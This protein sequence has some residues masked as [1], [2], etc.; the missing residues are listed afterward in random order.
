MLFAFRV[1]IVM[2][3]Y[4][5]HYRYVLASQSLARQGSGRK[6]FGVDWIL[7]PQSWNHEASRW[8][9]RWRCTINFT[10]PD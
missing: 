2:Y 6:L 5:D 10:S 8:L 3:G 7:D 9:D 1:D 4:I